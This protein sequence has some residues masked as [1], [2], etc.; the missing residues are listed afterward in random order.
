[1]RVL[2]FTNC[3][4]LPVTR[5]FRRHDLASGGWMDSLRLELQ[6]YPALELGVA[7]ASE[8]DYRFFEEGGT[9]FY[10]LPNPSKNRNL[11]SIYRRWFPTIKFPE[12]MRKCLE[13]IE[14]FK[15]DVI[16]VHGSESYFGAIA[17]E[18]SIPTVLSIQG[19][20]TILE[21]FYY[22]GYTYK[23]KLSDVF[24][25]EFL[26]G[27]DSF[28]D[29]RYISKS[30]I[31]EMQILKTC[32]NF[33]GRTEFDK[34]FLALINPGASYYHCDEILRHCFYLGEWA[35]EFSDKSIIFCTCSSPAPY[36]G[37]DCLF[38]AFYIL[39]TNDFKN[40][41][42]RIA[43]PIQNSPSWH[44]LRKKMDTLNLTEDVV[45][46][47]LS[48]P[49][50]IVT[51]LERANVF[52]LPSYAENSPNSLAEAM[53]VGTPCIASAVG[54]VPSM[55]THGKDGLLFP[56]G[57]AYSLAGM[58]A[59]IIREPSTAKSISYNA[60]ISALARHNPQ[61]IAISMMNI[62]SELK[63]NSRLNLA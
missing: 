40:V 45:L 25:I 60:K 53:L 27:I 31:R 1:M 48:S 6:N 32:E 12:G 15:P 21:L 16:H 52:V 8:F 57:D 7:S 51:E 3:P 58:I 43:G 24:S 56:S 30:A 28:H 13:I 18:I 42:L 14:E 36:K 23:D 35:P 37:L 20:L 4:L 39:K 50:M 59:K 19:I 29:Y 22:G 63:E 54:G 10:N 41:Q 11:F 62:Y 17:K 33:I 61:K 47:G 38:N 55:V 9:K 44:V 46:L 26:R 2:W 5:K 34:N 49:E